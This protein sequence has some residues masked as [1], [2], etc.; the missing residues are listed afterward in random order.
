MPDE[1]QKPA[2]VK[3]TAKPVKPE[4]ETP[5]EGK[6]LDVTSIEDAKAKISDIEVIGNV[7]AWQLLSKA[8]SKSGKWMKSTKALYIPGY[9]VVLQVSTQQGDNVAE[10]I[11]LIPNVKIVD[12]VNGGKKLVA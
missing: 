11:T 5:V 12:D 10:A 8:S 7:D 2:I 1:E 3:Q 6:V 4:S 9:G